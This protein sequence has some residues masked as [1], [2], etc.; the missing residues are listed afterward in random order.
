MAR[1]VV[2]TAGP[3]AAS[4][5]TKIAL[6]QKAAGAQYL[7]L[8][9]AAGSFSAN[10]ICASQTPG[11][12]VDLT[13]NGSA[14][15]GGVAYL[16]TPQRIYIT[17]GSNESG[18]TFT[19]YG[20]SY[21]PGGVSTFGVTETVTGA[22]ASRVSSANQYLTITRIAVSGATTGAIT[23]GAYGPATL[24]TARRVLFT[25]TGNDSGITYFVS[26]LD[27]SGIPIT[28]TLAGVNNPSTAYTV[29]DYAVINSIL[30]S[31]AVGTALT[32][33]TNGICSSPWCR[34]DEM[35]AM[36]PTA[37]QVDG[38]GTVN[39]TV[40]Q[41]LNDPNSP[42]N[43]VAAASVDWVNHPDSGLVA[44]TTTTGVQGNYAYTPTFARVTMNSNGGVTA[45][46]RATFLQNYQG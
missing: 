28:E 25:P 39:W 32:V 34:F 35:G 4:S 26:G 20:T 18:K 2:V 8:D 15:S 6:S 31:G 46:A 41:T 21:T 11:G 45:Y 30:T 37:V 1:A 36:A 44:Q 5:A 14:A 13:I 33:G 7:V 23:V 22:N 29:L 12:A 10:N 17:G 3:L 24:D 27:G 19:I 16:G 42:T 9:G 38:S 40:Q 43:P